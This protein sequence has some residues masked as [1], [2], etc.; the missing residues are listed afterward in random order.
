MTVLLMKLMTMRLMAVEATMMIMM[1]T[2]CIISTTQDMGSLVQ[3]PAQR[4][5]SAL[6]LV[7]SGARMLRVKKSL[8]FRLASPQALEHTRTLVSKHP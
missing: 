2:G 4:T 7:S 3:T 1:M 6:L 5:H 8:F